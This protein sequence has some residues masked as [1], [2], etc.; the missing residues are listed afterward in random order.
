MKNMEKRTMAETIAEAMAQDTL[1]SQKE[2][3]TEQITGVIAFLVDQRT[4][5]LSEIRQHREKRCGG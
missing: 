2:E 5:L 1:A 4:R 3:Q